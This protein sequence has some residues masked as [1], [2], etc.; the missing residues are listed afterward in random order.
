MNI[1]I[2]LDPESD[3]EVEFM[4]RVA[5]ARNDALDAGM[6]EEDVARTLSVFAEGVLSGSFENQDVGSENKESVVC[7]LCGL[8]VEDVEVMGIGEE[9]VLVPCGCRVTF[10]ELPQKVRDDILDS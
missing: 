6:S 7:P 10:E 8:T 5:M 9:P 3:A 1:E 4:E 2:V